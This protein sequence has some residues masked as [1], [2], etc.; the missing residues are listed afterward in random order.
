MSQDNKNWKV[1]QMRL[2]RTMTK[3][4]MVHALKTETHLEFGRWSGTADAHGIC[5]VC[6]VGSVLR[7]HV[8]LCQIDKIANS[9]TENSIG[10]S[11]ASAMDWNKWEGCTAEDIAKNPLA[12]LSALFETRARTVG[13]GTA[14]A[15]CIEMVKSDCFPDKIEIGWTTGNP[16]AAKYQKVTSKVIS[17]KSKEQR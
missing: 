13:L 3:A 15:D 7:E 6:A 8:S 1:G 9:L 4:G 12:A 14:R 5:T 17:Q 10:P 16:G 11:S 2:T